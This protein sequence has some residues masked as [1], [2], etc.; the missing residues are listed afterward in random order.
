MSTRDIV[1]DSSY[2]TAANGS[3]TE[4]TRLDDAMRRADELLVT[5]LKSDERRRNRRRIIILSIGGLV[6]LA[7]CCALLLLFAAQGDSSTDAAVALEHFRTDQPNAEAEVVAAGE[8]AV[9]GLAKIMFDKKLQAQ[10]RFLAA[11]A[12]G[13]IGSKKAVKPLL[14]A[15]KDPDFNVR[16]CAALALGK[17]GDPSVRPALEKLAKEDPFAWS[18]PQTGAVHYLVREDA[19]QAIVKLPGQ[20]APDT[21]KQLASPP[22]K[23]P[24]EKIAPALEKFRANQP[25]AYPELVALG[26]SAVGE[27]SQILAD[28]KLKVEQRFTAANLLGDIKSKQA[29]KPLLESLK[30]PEFNVRRCAAL[31]LGKIGDSSVRPALEKVAK[32]DPFAWTDP[33]TGKVR[34]LVRE[35][36]QQAL[37]LLTA[38]PSATDGSSLEPPTET[39][40]DDASKLPPSPAKVK[41]AKL[42]WPFPGSFKDQNV[43]NNYQQPTD[44]YI[45]GGLDILQPA[46]TEVRAVADGYV[47]TIFTNYPDWKTHHFFVIAT[48]EG[49]SEGWC[50]THV[51]PDTYTFKI[52]DKITA[53]QVLG[54]LVDFYVGHNKGQDHL[55]LHYVRFTKDRVGK[56]ELQSLVDP[57]LFFDWVDVAAPHIQDPLRFVRKNSFDEFLPDAQ[58]DITVSGQV[59][60]IAGISDTCDES[61]LGNWMVPV[62]TLEIDGQNIPPWRKLVLDQRGPL[63]GKEQPTVLYLSSEESMRWA[64]NVPAFPHI[65]YLKTTSTDGNGVIE[66]NDRLYSWNTNQLDAKGQRLFPNGSY[67]VTVRAWDL[68]GNRAQCTTNVRVFNQPRVGSA[69]TS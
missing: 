19:L 61:T 27:L 6:M 44:I 49:D 10:Q 33:Q 12:L 46:G 52:G 69:S 67:D 17:I 37:Q 58:G 60:I 15:L 7:A 26:E 62:V 43:W 24:P 3:P 9:D 1:T 11:N 51:D 22:A 31:A 47:A 48:E 42:S 29:I 64:K 34:Y 13:D 36:A 59:E 8:A 45:H 30:D 23:A 53:G 63:T 14:Q 18:D 55:H 65:F 56:V 35:D 40:L 39:F 57:L 21:K 20:T 28:K 66:P 38:G 54:K 25:V 5:S 4:Q 16:R 68:K 41:L 32:D 2:G 50:Y